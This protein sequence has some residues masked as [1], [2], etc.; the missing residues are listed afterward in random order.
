MRSVS[1]SSISKLFHPDFCPRC[2]WLKFHFMP[3]EEHPFYL[4][5]AGILSRLDSYTKRVVK[6]QLAGKETPA[7]LKEL[8]KLGPENKYVS[9]SLWEKTFQNLNVR[10]IADL[11]IEDPDGHWYIADY[12]TAAWSEVQRK[13]WPIYEVQAN[14]YGWLARAREKVDVRGL[15][16]IYFEAQTEHLT[17]SEN[18]DLLL[19]F[20]AFARPVAVWDDRQVEDLLTRAQEIICSETPPRGREGCPKCAVYDQWREKLP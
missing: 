14:L 1:V 15:G 12:K 11:I 7:Y 2:S 20:K 6:G 4:P 8:F 19:P 18:Y 9:P 13:I 5:F 10:G 3:E 17:L 16:I